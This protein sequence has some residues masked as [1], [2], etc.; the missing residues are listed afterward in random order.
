M[1]WQRQVAAEFPHVDVRGHAGRRIRKPRVDHLLLLVYGA[2]RVVGDLLVHV[3]PAEQ[4]PAAEIN[5]RDVL[6]DATERA[7]R[8]DAALPALLL[9]ALQDLL[10]DRQE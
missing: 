5:S 7:L 4:I 3:L 2:D 8:D 9:E 6:V 10:L 1:Q